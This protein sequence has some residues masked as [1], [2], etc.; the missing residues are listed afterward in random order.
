MSQEPTHFAAQFA[1]TQVAR[2]HQTSRSRAASTTSNTASNHLARQRPP[3][4]STT[5]NTTSTHLASTTSNT[6]SNH[7]VDDHGPRRARRARRR[8]GPDLPAGR[9]VRVRVPQRRGGRGRARRPRRPRLRRGERGGLRVLR[10]HDAPRGAGPADRGG[11][12]HLLRLRFQMEQARRRAVL[13][14]RRGQGLEAVR[15]V[16]R[17]VRPRL[18]ERPPLVRVVRRVRHPRRAQVPR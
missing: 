12:G 8:C 6:T 7:H 16:V 3:T 14:A 13:L 1:T 10:R 15:R 18:R 11:A 17:V 5:G 9:R 4:A 2:R